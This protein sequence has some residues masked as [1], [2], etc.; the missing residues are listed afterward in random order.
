MKLVDKLPPLAFAAISIF[1]WASLAALGKQLGNLPPFLLVGV[2]LCIGGIFGLRY[3]RNWANITYSRIVLGIYG[4]FGFH[5]FLFLALKRAPAIE[6]NLI[7]YLWPLLIV[8]LAP[9]FMPHTK[10]TVWHIGGGVLG[11]LGAMVLTL[12][13]AQGF[14][15]QYAV[16][17]SCAA[18]SAFVWASYSLLTRRMGPSPRGAV[19][20][21]CL[22][23]GVLS[24][25]CHAV[26][27]PSANIGNRDWLWLLI[28]GGGPMGLAF[29]T[30]DAALQ[31]GDVHAI[32]ALS[33]A[34]PLLSTAAL[35]LVGAGQ[36]GWSAAAALILIVAGAVL[37]GR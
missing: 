30:W 27:E 14:E 25:V 24:L 21:Y 37:A 7:N 20:L 15:V 18:V 11:F 5:F 17:Y 16:G 34:T 36:L 32:A 28:L 6:T 19:G 4:L 23:S 10:L 26:F 8:L 1:L 9:V 33:Y 13:K 29:Y 22:V 31:R 12:G 2:A 3:W 35:W